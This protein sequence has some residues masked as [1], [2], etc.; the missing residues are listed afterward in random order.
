MKLQ[1]K[2]IEGFLA[3][4]KPDCR[5]LLVH[6]PDHGLIGERVRSLIQ[7]AIPDLAD[8]NDPFRVTLLDG[9]DITRETARIADEANTLSMIGGVRLIWVKDADDGNVAAVKQ[10][11]ERADHNSLVMLEAGELP[12]KSQLRKLCEDSAK[13]A[14]IPCY[15]EDEAALLPFIQTALQ[16]NGIAIARDA[17]QFLASRLV[18]D[19]ALARSEIDKLITYAGDQKTLDLD[20]VRAVSFDAAELEMDQLAYAMTAGQAERLLRI[21]DRL[22]A[23]GTASVALIRA[24]IR[25]LQRLHITKARIE[26]GSAPQVAMKQLYPQIFFKQEAAFLG[27]LQRYSLT[28]FEKMLTRLQTLEKQCKT[29]NLPDQTIV[30]QTLLQF[31]VR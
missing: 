6:G 11:L 9:D 29:S 15:V 1:G 20:D 8:L 17:L 28:A 23:E 24:C 31:A 27:A 3:R 14:A 12:A 16:Q 5:A 2:A 4:P 7:K 26:D 21:L 13:A 19:R 22:Y 18:G 10:Y 25:H 30:S